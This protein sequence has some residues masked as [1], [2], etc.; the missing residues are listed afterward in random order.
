[1][2]R[3]SLV[4]FAL[5]VIASASLAASPAVAAVDLCA[6]RLLVLSAFPAEIDGLL[7]HA[8]LTDSIHA[9]G[10]SFYLGTLAGNDVVL[11][12]TGIGINNVTATT[13]LAAETFTCDG[14]TSLTGVVFSGVSGGNARIG[15]VTI[16]AR[17]TIDGGT[18]W[19]D[20]DPH[21][22]SVA[23]QAASSVTLARAVPV[24]DLAC[25]G[26]DPRLVA[27]VSME[28]APQ[29]I[30][31]GDGASADPFGG[32]TLPCAPGGGDVF[33][34][35]P[36]R[37]PSHAEPDVGAFVSGA[38]PFI[39]PDFFR[40]YG[41]SP[42]A[43]DPRF[44]AVDMETAGAAGIASRHNLP[45]IAFRALSDGEGDPLML[46]GFP[47]QFF[48]YRQLAADNAATVAMAFLAAWAE[49]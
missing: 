48:Y 21:M 41:E 12:L 32:R 35:E 43:A 11:A 42:P 40:D 25:V 7:S 36:C 8:S 39:D 6:P 3:K 17:W 28:Q 38:L 24:G 47:F 15:D 19:V 31:G 1:M 44:D 4:V 22:L 2:I 34:C 16:P 37:A 13:Q 45:F 10:R 26:I 23:T 9:G 5:A 46:P 27:T 49:G 33:G 18:T 14:Q 29:L 30:I 20:V